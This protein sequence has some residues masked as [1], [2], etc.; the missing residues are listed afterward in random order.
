MCESRRV[1]IGEAFDRAAARANDPETPD[2]ETNAANAASDDELYRA[3]L[4][5]ASSP[6]GV[7]VKARMARHEL[8]S[9]VGISR[10]QAAGVLLSS[11][12]ADLGV[13]PAPLPCPAAPA[14]VNPA[15]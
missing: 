1:A 7:H 4:I 8:E 11:L 9:G 10:D 15:G 2:D 14:P 6:A 5:P 13:P 12:L 3:A